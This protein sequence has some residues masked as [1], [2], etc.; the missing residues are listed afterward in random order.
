LAPHHLIEL[1]VEL[2]LVQQLPARGAVDLGA[3]LGDAVFVSVL[4]LG[5]TGDQARQDVIAEREIGGRRRRPHPE[6]DDR[7][8]HDPEYDRPNSDLATGM[9]QGVAVARLCDRGRCRMRGRT[10][11]G[12]PAIILRMM[13]LVVFGMVT[14]TVRHRHSHAGRMGSVRQ[15]FPRRY[16]PFM[17]N[18]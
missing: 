14:R 11:R 2:F 13:V 16:E 15:K 12:R 6:Q 5:L 7:A 3:Q 9:G 10:A 17:V 8:D 1:L 4:H 18:F